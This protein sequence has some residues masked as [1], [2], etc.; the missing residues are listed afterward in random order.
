MNNDDDIKNMNDEDTIYFDDN[1]KYENGG[2]LPYTEE[3]MVEQ[4]RPLTNTNSIEYDEDDYESDM[5]NVGNDDFGTR[6]KIIIGYIALLIIIVFIIIFA[7][8]K[9]K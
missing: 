5:Y 1:K 6:K 8:I 7:N 9:L 3:D 2:N 4:T